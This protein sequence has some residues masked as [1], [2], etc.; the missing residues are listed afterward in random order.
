MNNTNPPSD[1]GNGN[2]AP[3]D[4]GP[5]AP[6]AGPADAGY[7]AECVGVMPGSTGAA[8][9]FTVPYGATCTSSTSDGT[10][11]LV[12]ETH[13]ASS[14]KWNLFDTNGQWMGNFSG[15]TPLHPQPSGFQGYSGGCDYWWKNN[16]DPKMFVPLE[17][18]AIVE[19]AFS[20]GTIAVGTGVVVHR[21]DATGQET[22][23]AQAT[24]P[25]TPWAAAEDQSGAILA[26]VQGKGVWFDLSSSTAGKPFDL[27]PGSQAIARA[28]SGGGIAVRLDGH[29]AGV[30]NPG[31][32]SLTAAPAWLPDNSDFALV[33]GGKAYAILQASNEIQL[34]STLGNMCGTVRFS[35]SNLSVGADGTVIGSSG[36]GGC[37]KI[38]W[39]SALK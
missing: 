29:W 18:D 21:V 1:G 30:V 8:L 26:I 7:A 27:G 12:A 20:T 19:S 14:L 15:G 28:L 25:G 38:F 24:I 4:G 35:A 16:G 2:P 9:T 22:A 36:A 31:Q 37:T 5:P 32:T 33:R 3:S 13:D 10:G 11:V 17:P 39:R 34:V 6:D 23:R